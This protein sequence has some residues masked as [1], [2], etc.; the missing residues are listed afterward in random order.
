MDSIR[1]KRF[2]KLAGIAQNSSEVRDRSSERV[3]VIKSKKNR[4]NINKN[5]SLK[6]PNIKIFKESIVFQDRSKEKKKPEVNISSVK[7]IK[8]FKEI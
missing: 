4:K 8:E 5:Q 6:L 7:E 1:S 2:E 3:K